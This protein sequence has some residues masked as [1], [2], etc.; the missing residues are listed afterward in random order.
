[1]I[2]QVCGAVIFVVAHLPPWPKAVTRLPRRKTELNK[3]GIL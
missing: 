3:Q 2:L 1:M